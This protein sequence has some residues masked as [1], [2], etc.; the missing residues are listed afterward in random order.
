MKN[1]LFF[2]GSMEG[3]KAKQTVNQFFNVPNAAL[4]AG[5]FSNAVNAN[6]TT[7]D[8]LRP[9][10]RQRRRHRPHA[11]PEQPDSGQPHQP[12]CVAAAG[13]LPG[14]ERARA[15]APAGL[16]NN[17]FRPERRAPPI[18]TTTTARSTS[19]APS[20]HQI[21]G[22]FS[23]LDA[24]VDD[25]TYFL[26]PDPNGTRRRRQHQGLPVHRR[27]DLDAQQQHGVGHDVRLLPPG[28]GRARSGRQARQLR[29]R[30]ARHS[31]HQRPGRR[32]SADPRY[33]GIPRVP[34]AASRT[35][36]TSK[37]GCRSIRDERTYSFT[38]NVSKIMGRHDLRAGYTANYLWL[39]HWQPEIDNPRGRFDFTSTQHHGAPRRPGRTT[40]TTSYAAFLLGLPGTITRACRPRR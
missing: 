16:T 20:A 12:D 17:Y 33:G 37:A 30:H 25:R 5:D 35:S 18:A 2:F 32:R 38:T 11:V 22:K 39:N 14:A 8:H 34:H 24:V 9:D 7:A 1:R 27:P 13:V 23:Y 31:R 26:I 28:A 29:P 3:Y 6:G 15:R 4:R 21:W 40:S 19:T 10:H 36:A